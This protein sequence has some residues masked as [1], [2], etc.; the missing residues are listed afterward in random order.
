MSLDWVWNPVV[1]VL[2]LVDDL[3]TQEHDGQVYG[4]L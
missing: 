4:I 3:Y 1:M 2:A